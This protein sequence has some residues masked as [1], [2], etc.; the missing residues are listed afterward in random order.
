MEKV[1]VRRGVKMVDVDWGVWDGEYFCWFYDDL[2][3]QVV[4]AC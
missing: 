1:A 3:C 4:L 2:V